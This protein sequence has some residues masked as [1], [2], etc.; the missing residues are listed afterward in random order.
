MYLCFFLAQ[1]PSMM[2]DA[3]KYR[4]E[5]I[6]YPD[7]PAPPVHLN[8]TC[9]QEEEQNFIC[10]VQYIVRITKVKEKDLFL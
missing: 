3:N 4:A 8:I 9:I 1:L 5:C 6:Y 2:N 7:A 10:V